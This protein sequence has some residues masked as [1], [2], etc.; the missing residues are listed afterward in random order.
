MN[1]LRLVIRVLCLLPFATGLLDLLRGA[2]YLRSGGAVI[3]DAVAADPVL[4]SQ[5]K[6]WGA[7]WLGYGLTL[8]RT[9]SDLRANA[10]LFRLLM[11]VLFLS[12]VGRGAAAI[13]FG[14]PGRALEGAMGLELIGTPLLLLW[15]RT[16]LR[17]ADRR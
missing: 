4:N 5:V 8:W 15:H 11:G 14:R 9:S 3:P 10:G 2:A 1:A 17:G 13:Q 16:A 7:I 6:F 12:G